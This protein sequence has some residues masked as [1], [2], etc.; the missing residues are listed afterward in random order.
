MFEISQMHAENARQCTW[1]A[2][3]VQEELQYKEDHIL[4]TVQHI[5]DCNP[6]IP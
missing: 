1:D 2:P 4:Y 6:G 5:S 3:N